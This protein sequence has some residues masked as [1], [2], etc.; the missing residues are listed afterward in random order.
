M[1]APQWNYRGDVND[2]IYISDVVWT[3]GV[4]GV[5]PSTNAIATTAGKNHD[6]ESPEL[7]FVDL[8]TIWKNQWNDR[9]V[10]GNQ[11]VTR[12][13]RHRNPTLSYFETFWSFN[14]DNNTNDD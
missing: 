3:A 10:D 9:T 13:K 11:I 6:F 1:V 4:N 5:L 8:G 7:V 14:I 12:G 2:L